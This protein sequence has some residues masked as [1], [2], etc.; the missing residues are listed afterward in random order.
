[1]RSWPQLALWALCS[2]LSPA[3]G[4]GQQ[5]VVSW[6]NNTEA[7]LMGYK[8]YHGTASRVYSDSQ[9]VGFANRAPEDGRREW[10]VNITYDQR[11]FFAVMA[12]DT[13][14]NISDYSN[15]ASLELSQSESVWIDP[16]TVYSLIGASVV[17]DT[18]KIYGRGKRNAGFVFNN[19]FD[20]SLVVVS[21]QSRMA[22]YGACVDTARFLLVNGE[23]FLNTTFWGL[24]N[25]EP[26]RSDTI[27]FDFREDCH[28]IGVSD[29]KI[30]VFDI[31]V[32]LFHVEQPFITRRGTRIWYNTRQYSLPH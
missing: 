6:E 12:Y 28:V 7:D 11:W 26:I 25:T 9:D 23:P 13:A 21:F 2:I 17:R 5:A 16:Q 1:M 22:G 15:E 31:W 19:P 27:V 14:W 24:F 3:L 4:L 29:T 20:D 8:V 18:I 30:Y 10:V 32:S